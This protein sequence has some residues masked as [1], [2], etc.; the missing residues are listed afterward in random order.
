MNICYSGEEDEAKEE[1]GNDDAE[2]MMMVR[3]Q[4]NQILDAE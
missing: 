2:Q 3:G 1:L 4:H